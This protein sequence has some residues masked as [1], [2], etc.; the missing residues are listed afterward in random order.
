[1]KDGH[2]YVV[3]GKCGGIWNIA[4]E[5][6]TRYGYLCPQCRYRK[7]KEEPHGQAV[8]DLSGGTVFS[9]GDHRT[10]VGRNQATP[11]GQA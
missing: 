3:C 8:C 11:E 7:R 1:M 10:D 5:Q 9:G 6:D 4:K 2:R